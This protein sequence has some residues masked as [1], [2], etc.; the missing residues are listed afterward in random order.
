MT[1]WILV[2]VIAGGILSLINTGVI[3]YLYFQQIQLLEFIQD[4]LG[5]L[6]SHSRLHKIGIM[7]D[8]VLSQKI[9]RLEGLL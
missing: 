1:D 3:A 4:I 7:K 6:E 2:S 5:I 9:N 8:T